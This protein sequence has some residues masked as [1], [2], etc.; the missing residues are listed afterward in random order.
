METDNDSEADDEKKMLKKK[1]KTTHA[2]QSLDDLLH[3]FTAGEDEHFFQLATK[4][5]GKVETLTRQ[6]KKELNISCF[7]K[8]SNC[9]FIIT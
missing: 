4:T 5:I 2:A 8:K 9:R 6:C 3:F 7:F 1:M